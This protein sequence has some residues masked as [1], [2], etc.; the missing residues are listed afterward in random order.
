MEHSYAINSTLFSPNVLYQKH[1]RRQALSEKEKAII[2]NVYCFFRRENPKNT[3]EEI[4]ERTAA[5]TAISKSTVYR[6]KSERK[7]EANQSRA[8]GNFHRTPRRSRKR[9]CD[10][11]DECQIRQKIHREFFFQE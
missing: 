1:L 10:E 3:K 2:I 7:N 4:V 8:Q 5:A 6:I 11:F 9:K